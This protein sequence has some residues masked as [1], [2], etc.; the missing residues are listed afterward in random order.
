MERIVIFERTDL[1]RALGHL[2]AEGIDHNAD[3][4]GAPVIW[5]HNNADAE[6][7]AKLLCARGISAVH[8][9]WH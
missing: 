8:Q 1:A 3:E 9:P 6:P 7:A 4:S 2:C 5:L